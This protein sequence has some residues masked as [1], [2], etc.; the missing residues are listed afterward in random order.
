MSRFRGR[1]IRSDWGRPATHTRC[2]ET[3]RERD[4]SAY[5]A[6]EDSVFSPESTPEA[7]AR[8]R[9]IFYVDKFALRATA[10]PPEA[11]GP[12]AETAAL[13]QLRIASRFRCRKVK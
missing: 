2:E 5:A 1:S 6:P 12:A 13:H 8:S 7:A 11:G 4:S 9:R 10:C 3:S